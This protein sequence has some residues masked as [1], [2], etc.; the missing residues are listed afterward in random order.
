MSFSEERR[1]TIS[2]ENRSIQELNQFID[3][4]Q[5]Q[6][7]DDLVVLGQR[8]LHKKMEYI[9]EAEKEADQFHKNYE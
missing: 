3:S 9:R 6:G 2:L 8:I 1:L 5:K 7:R 4:V